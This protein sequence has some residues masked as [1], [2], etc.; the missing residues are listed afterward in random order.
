MDKEKEK[1]KI[2]KLLE[3]D[4]V[5]T[6]AVAEF[7]KEHYWKTLVLLLE[8]ELEKKIIREK[9]PKQTFWHLVGFKT[10]YELG[11]SEPC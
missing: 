3:R 2:L 4:S 5:T 11:G 6:N 8:L 1:Q 10:A 9:K 7:L